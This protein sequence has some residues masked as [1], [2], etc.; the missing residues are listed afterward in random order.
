M[1]LEALEFQA[2]REQFDDVGLI[3]DDEDRASGRFSGSAAMAIP[4]N[5]SQFPGNEAAEHAVNFL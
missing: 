3:V 1:D 4:S 5:V 2:H